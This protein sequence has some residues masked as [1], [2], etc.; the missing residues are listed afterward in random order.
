MNKKNKVMIVLTIML[1]IILVTK[2]LY[3]DEVNPIE[4]DEQKFKQFIEK[5]IEEG[6]ENLGLLNKTGLVSFK[7]VKIQRINDENSQL[8]GEGIFEGKYKAKVRGYLFHIIPYS[9]FSVELE[10]AVK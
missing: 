2:S 7:V 5:R 3:L 6:K 8:S 4:E 10:P 1:F 9:E